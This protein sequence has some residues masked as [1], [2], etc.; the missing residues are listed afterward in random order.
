MGKLY[1][2]GTPIG[3][4]KDITYRAVETLQNV[5]IILCE[6]TRTSQKLLNHYDIHKITY[7]YHNFN[8]K[9]SSKEIVRLIAEEDKNIALI[10]DAGMPVISDP[11]FTLINECNNHNI[12]IDIISGPTALI[13]AVIKANFG[14][15]FSFL[16]FLKDKSIQRQ[17]ELKKLGYGVYVAYV[18][19]HK[20]ISTLE[21]FGTVFNDDVELFL[22]KEMT[23][24]FETEYRGSYK[25]IIDQLDGNVKGEFVLVF[26]IKKIKKE[27]INKYK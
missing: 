27:K 10:S 13:H 11:G 14:A 22:I 6:D 20:L 9:Q 23:K 1:I 15:T 3:N 17:N 4:L 7:A 18:S 5:D 26:N 25:N 19:P 2:V 16:G 12:D 24:K 8:E 21:D